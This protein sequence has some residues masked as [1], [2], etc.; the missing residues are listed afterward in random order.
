[1]LEAVVGGA[2]ATEFQVVIEDKPGALA[3]LGVALGDGGVNIEALLGL[4][5]EGRSTV[6]FV[7]NNRDA[8]A[9]VLDAGGLA[10]RGARCSSC[11]SSISRACSATS[12]W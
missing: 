8:A 10:I 7:P 11:A 12:H 1:M 5:L 9:S 3:K 6:Q 4:S 2:M